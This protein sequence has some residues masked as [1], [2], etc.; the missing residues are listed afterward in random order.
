MNTVSLATADI[1]LAA[2]GVSLV[3]GIAVGAVSSV[4]IFLGL[5]GGSVPAS[6]FLSYALFIDPPSET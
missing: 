2:I 5:A 1:V 6:G 4:S 3:L